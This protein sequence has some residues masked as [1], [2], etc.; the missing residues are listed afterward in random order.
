MEV[1]GF[2]HLPT[3]IPTNISTTTMPAIVPTTVAGNKRKR[4]DG[5]EMNDTESAILL[6]EQQILESRKNYN[7]IVTLLNY[8]K[9]PESQQDNLSSVLAF[10]ALC[11]VFSKLIALGSLSKTRQTPENE[12]AIVQWLNERYI[13]FKDTLLTVLSGN[14]ISRQS[15]SLNLLMRLVKADAE[16]LGLSEESIWRN[17]TFSSVLEELVRSETAADARDEFTYMYVKEFSDARFHTFACLR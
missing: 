17:S 1:L 4:R 12:A 13:D 9:T 2:K 7:K 16:H 10:V 15:T 14:D 3:T 11:R 6:L 5:E 8:A